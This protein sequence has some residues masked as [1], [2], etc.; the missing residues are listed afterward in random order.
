MT[1]REFLQAMWSGKWHVLA[2]LLVVLV[3]GYVYAERQ[4]ASYRATAAVELQVE[5]A[6]RGDGS[7]VTVDPEASRALD[8]PVVTRAA[9][10]LGVA[11]PELASLAVERTFDP[12]THVATIAVTTTDRQLATRAAEAYATA[13]AEHLPAIVAERTAALDGQIAAV[14][15]QITEARTTLAAA[16]EDPVAT[17]VQAAGEATLSELIAEKTAYQSLVPPGQVATGAAD[18][19]PVGMEQRAVLGIALLAGLA[20]GAGVA[21]VRRGLDDRVRSADQAGEVADAPVLATISGA[22][23]AVRASARDQVLPVATRAATP[24]T[25]SVRELRTAVDVSLGHKDHVVVVVSAADPRAPRAF[26][27]ANLAASFALSGRRT[28]V[29]SGDLRR[30]TI[31]DM[32]PA[33][34]G[35][36]PPADRLR[37]TS[38]TNLWLYPV[39][40]RQSLD[41]ADYLATGAFRALLNELR[42]EADV[43]VIDA[44]PVLAAADATILGGYADGVVLVATL[45]K[46]ARAVLAEAARRLRTTGVR[47]T[48]LA[49]VGVGVDR[50]VTY[51][52]TYGERSRA[53]HA[54]TTRS[55]TGDH[56]EGR[57]AGAPPAEEADEPAVP[58]SAT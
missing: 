55:A 48:G 45:A 29:V 39:P 36:P 28:V 10:I 31:D 8:E 26:V 23:R 50:H 11:P 27:T 47:L 51:A 35:W 43:V 5:D 12:E 54:S 33:P 57:H 4:V 53:R 21:L 32:L 44:P 16:P 58:A 19:V 13:Y 49:V 9:E 42:V 37:P 18:V 22:R 7:V 6:G 46:T 17:A 41:P 14:S 3:A 34:A 2:A 38:I 40:E 25:E 24:F 30:P 20:L 1:L 52:S 15:V 56:P